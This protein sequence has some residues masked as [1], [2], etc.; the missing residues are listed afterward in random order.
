MRV[1]YRDRDTGHFVSK[2]TWERSHGR[3]GD[4]VRTY[5]DEPDYG[6]DL[7]IDLGDDEY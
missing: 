4:Y 5:Y 6:E 1:S 2:E 3:E 7:D